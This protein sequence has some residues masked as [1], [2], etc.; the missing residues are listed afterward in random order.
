L[1]V[2]NGYTQCYYRNSGFTDVVDS[3]DYINDD[4]CCNFNAD[5]YRLATEGEWEYFCRAG[6]LTA[7]SCPEDNYTSVTCFV[8]T[9]TDW[10]SP[11]SNEELWD[12]AVFCANDSGTSEAV[13][14][15]ASNPWNLKDIHGNVWE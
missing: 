8:C 9:E 10:Q 5:G 7:F 2:Q 4:H 1:S 14:N 11:N 6:T 13:G 15:K 12:H 3:E